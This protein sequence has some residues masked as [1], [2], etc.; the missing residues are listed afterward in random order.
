MGE[1]KKGTQF[2]NILPGVNEDILDIDWDALEDAWDAQK[3]LAEI[4]FRQAWAT[5][6]QT[7]AHKIDTAVRSLPP[8]I[9]LVLYKLLKYIAERV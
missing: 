2:K 9:Q 3:K 6:H 7:P 1:Q 5:I 8:D 4:P